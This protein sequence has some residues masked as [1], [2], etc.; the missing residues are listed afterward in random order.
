MMAN[1]VPTRRLQPFADALNARYGDYSLQP[2]RESE[3]ASGELRDRSLDGVTICMIDAKGVVSR[4]AKLPDHLHDHAFIMAPVSGELIVDQYDRVSRVTPGSALILDSMA[5]CTITVEDTCSALTIELNRAAFHR[6]GGISRD[7]CAR[8]LDVGSGVRGLYA[9]V[10]DTIA[11]NMDHCRPGDGDIVADLVVSLVGRFARDAGMSE[12][13]RIDPA[14]L[15]AMRD[16]VRSNVDDP[17]LS[18]DR[19]ARQFGLSRRSVYRQF[20][21]LGTTPA[22]WLWDVRLECADERLR[23]WRGSVS[24]VAYSVGFNDSSHFSRLYKRR[25]GRTPTMRHKASVRGPS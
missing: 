6:F 25:F 5:G 15:C 17:D 9:G 11:A 18:P 24:E 10:L 3:R 7:L 14:V 22:K 2:V 8:R 1:P 12:S 21:S 19:L 13:A 20:A 23:D 16:W 4:R